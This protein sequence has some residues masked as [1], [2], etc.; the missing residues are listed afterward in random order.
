MFLH[1]SWIWA[2]QLIFRTLEPDWQP[3]QNPPF[4]YHHE[5]R[6]GLNVQF[7]LESWLSFVVFFFLYQLTPL[8]EMNCS[9]YLTELFDPNQWGSSVQ[10]QLKCD[11]DPPLDS[12]ALF[13]IHHVVSHGFCCS[14]FAWLV[15][16]MPLLEE[17]ISRATQTLPSNNPGQDIWVVMKARKKVFPPFSEVL[18]SLKF[19]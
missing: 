18:T 17:Y 4:V 10:H 13:H 16:Y 3:Q 6:R 11:I 8:L 5:G 2:L 15:K 9:S 12:S 1:L 7:G 19:N 14:I